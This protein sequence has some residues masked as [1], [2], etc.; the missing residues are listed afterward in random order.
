MKKYL[1]PLL[2]SSCLFGCTTISKVA[3]ARP[4]EVKNFDS[5]GSIRSTYP[6]GGL[7]K[8]F[9]YSMALNSALN[10]AAKMGAT[11]F[12]LDPDSS[13]VFF[14]ISETASGTAYRQPSVILPTHR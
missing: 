3:I 4:D 6:L 14:A 5:I 9:T 11:H 7:F 13:P 1:I 10:K 8:N 12:V 2:A